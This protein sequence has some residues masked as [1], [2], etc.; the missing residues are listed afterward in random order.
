MNDSQTNFD[1]LL[2]DHSNNIV[3]ENNYKDLKI[4]PICSFSKGSSS[5]LRL[6]SRRI[7]VQIWKLQNENVKI[8]DTFSYSYTC[9]QMG[10]EGIIGYL[11][12]HETY[13]L[14]VGNHLGH[15]LHT[16]GWGE[17]KLKG[18][19]NWDLNPVPPSQET[20]HATKW[21]NEAG[22]LVHDVV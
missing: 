10:W 9:I 13:C 8:K 22:Y 2:T 16:Q 21:A 6:A 4:S 14:C 19:P 7:S 1:G 18:Q 12:S 15:N 3:Q 20:N 11:T 17:M 5:S